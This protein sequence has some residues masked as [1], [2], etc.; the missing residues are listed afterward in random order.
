M[1]KVEDVEHVARLA[2][3]T[4][5]DEEKRLYAEQLSKII[6][7]FDELK[8]VDTE[9]VEPMSHALDIANVLRDDVVV[10]PSGHE[11]LLKTAPA[12]EGA[13]FKVPKIGD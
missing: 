12:T 6:E 10:P 5:T 1:I 8:M 4:L 7:A 3:L 13:F 2:R 9:G 11:T